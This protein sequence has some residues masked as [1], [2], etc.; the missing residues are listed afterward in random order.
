[1]TSPLEINIKEL[2]GAGVLQR[3]LSLQA[4]DVGL[5]GDTCFSFQEPLRIFFRAQWAEGSPWV[6]GKTHSILSAA[7]ARCLVPF[8]YKVEAVFRMEISPVGPSASVKE[9]IRQS[10]LLTLPHSPLCQEKCRGLCPQC[11]QN[12]NEG[13]C[14]CPKEAKKM[15]S[16]FAKIRDIL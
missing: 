14:D 5:A 3:R 8:P 13:S 6:Q 4:G 2:R 12:F 9:E 16:P 11:G 10:I 15:P 1:M 7:C